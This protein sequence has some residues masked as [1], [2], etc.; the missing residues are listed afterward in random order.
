MAAL[1]QVKMKVFA[2]W[3]S[4]VENMITGKTLVNY[5]YLYKNK[6]GEKKFSKIYFITITNKHF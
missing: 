2:K 3:I 1:Q 4:R 6:D 5:I